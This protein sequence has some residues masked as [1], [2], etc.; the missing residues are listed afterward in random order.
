VVEL[1]PLIDT[2]SQ[3]SNEAGEVIAGVQ[4]DLGPG[5]LWKQTRDGH[6]RLIIL[7]A[8]RMLF[9]W[10]SSRTLGGGQLAQ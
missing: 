10:G 4:W 7:S 3:R 2:S 9:I 6:W 1:H 8:L 5:N